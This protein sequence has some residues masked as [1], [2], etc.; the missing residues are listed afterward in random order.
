LKYILSNN[1]AYQSYKK[2][3]HY[4]A[5]ES[6]S[7]GVLAFKY[8]ENDENP[9]EKFGDMCLYKNGYVIVCVDKVTKSLKK[10]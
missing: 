2:H 3:G 7:D 6:E 1:S 4:W 9:F 5:G 10:I 8:E